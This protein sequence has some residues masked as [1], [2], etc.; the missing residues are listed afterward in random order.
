MTQAYRT[1]LALAGLALAAAALVAPAKAGADGRLA[2]GASEADL[3]V[4]PFVAA[5]GNIKAYAEICHIA[6][7]AQAA[8]L[9]KAMGVAEI[10][11][12]GRYQQL[13]MDDGLLKQAEAKAY[14]QAINIHNL[15]QQAPACAS[16]PRQIDSLYA[17]TAIEGADFIQYQAKSNPQGHAP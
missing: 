2:P 12:R 10:V 15:T 4:F 9:A 8:R 7:T 1:P 11:A 14:S 3:Q 6:G 13:G 5:I 17:W 16:F